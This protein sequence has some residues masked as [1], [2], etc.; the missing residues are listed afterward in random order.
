MTNTTS[1]E[2]IEYN[3]K[4]DEIVQKGLLQNNETKSK[5]LKDREKAVLNRLIKYEIIS[6]HIE[7]ARCSSK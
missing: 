7:K 1:E 2:I 5:Y 3:K 6:L 4:Y